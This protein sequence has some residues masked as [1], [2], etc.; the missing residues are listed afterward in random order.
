MLFPVNHPPPLALS[1]FPLPLLQRSLSLKETIWK[2]KKILN[3]II[4][5]DQVCLYKDVLAAA[6][7]VHLKLDAKG[8]QVGD[9]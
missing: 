6:S 4:V 2:G 9:K 1:N 3:Q 8:P 7:K 5:L